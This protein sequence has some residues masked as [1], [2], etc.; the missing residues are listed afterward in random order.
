[1]TSS[2]RHQRQTLRGSRLRRLR[3]E[4]LPHLPAVA[5][6]LPAEDSN[7]SAGAPQNTPAEIIA[8]LKRNLTPD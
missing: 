7:W 4:M 3:A 5:E 2:I 8:K 6:F 1:L